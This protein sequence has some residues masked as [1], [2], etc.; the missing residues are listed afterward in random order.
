MTSVQINNAKNFTLPLSHPTWDYLNTTLQGGP[1]FQI[2]YGNGHGKSTVLHAVAEKFH[3][4]YIQLV[5]PRELLRCRF[6]NHILAVAEWDS[7]VK[8]PC[9]VI[10]RLLEL[11]NTIILVSN[12]LPI[13]V[14]P[15]ATLLDKTHVIPFNRPFYNTGIDPRHVEEHYTYALDEQG[16]RRSTPTPECQEAKNQLRLIAEFT[17]WPAM[18][19]SAPTIPCVP[20]PLATPA[21][22]APSLP[23][24]PPTLI[25]KE[26]EIDKTVK[27]IEGSKSEEK[28]LC[29]NVPCAVP[30]NTVIPT[31]VPA[32]V[33]PP[34]VPSTPAAPPSESWENSKKVVENEKKLKEANDYPT[35]DTA[36]VEPPNYAEITCLLIHRIADRPDDVLTIRPDPESDGFLIKLDQKYLGSSMTFRLEVNALPDYL[37]SF[38][39]CLDADEDGYAHVQFVVPLYPAVVVKRRRALLHLNNH[40]LPQ[41]HFL[42]HLND[43]PVDEIVRGPFSSLP[44]V[45]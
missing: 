29:F 42:L 33:V 22:K 10:L 20:A 43:W 8:I 26:I 37:R 31:V 4:S 19:P 32:T 12:T 30:V 40:V 17:G 13:I 36:P 9:A 11:G 41:I 28:P 3:Y 35:D 25:M 44:P 21:P 16:F 1:N 2:W 27:K 23:D 6:K 24:L 14:N 38:F 45:A 39:R 5:E 7:E 34:A 15:T 18:P